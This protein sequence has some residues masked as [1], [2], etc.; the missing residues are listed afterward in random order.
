[1]KKE[2]EKRNMWRILRTRL[3]KGMISKCNFPKT[4]LMKGQSDDSTSFRP[5]SD[6]DEYDAFSSWTELERSRR[7]WFL[8]GTKSRTVSSLAFL[9]SYRGKDVDTFCESNFCCL[10]VA[11]IILDK[12]GGKMWGIGNQIERIQ[13]TMW[14]RC[15][16]YVKSLCFDIISSA[17][18][19][20][21]A[22]IP[23]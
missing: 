17:H 13:F 4:I 11:A 3:S 12:C 9:I 16:A 8:P 1:M 20:F 2:K 5:W 23:F 22:N 21:S 14:Q 19:F 6:D 7:R 10:P 18:L 15:Q